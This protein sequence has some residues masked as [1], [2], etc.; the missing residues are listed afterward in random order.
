MT[1]GVSPLHHPHPVPTF[2]DRAFAQYDEIWAR[3]APRCRVQPELRV[4]G[5][6]TGAVEL[7]VTDG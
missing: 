4:F 5:T 6:L 7:E 1:S 2:I 3:R